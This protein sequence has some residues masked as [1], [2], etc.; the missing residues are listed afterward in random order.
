MVMTVK[1]RAE[2]RR[3]IVAHLLYYVFGVSNADRKIALV[4]GR[5]SAPAR[6]L[7]QYPRVAALA[8]FDAW[9]SISCERIGW[10]ILILAQQPGGN[11]G[12]HDGDDSTQGGRRRDGGNPRERARMGDAPLPWSIEQDDVPPRQ[13]SDRPSPTPASCATS[14]VPTT[15]FTGTSSRR[16]GTSSKAFSRSAARPIGRAR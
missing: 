8:R 4:L 14:P 2:A 7:G 15:Q 1:F 9:L 16:F 5:Y 12:S 11:D 6:R 13:R 10:G 3:N